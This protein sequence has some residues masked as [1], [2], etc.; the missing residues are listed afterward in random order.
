MSENKLSIPIAKTLRV[1]HRTLV[2]R[3][4]TS[5]R[6]GCIKSPDGEAFAPSPEGNIKGRI[7]GSPFRVSHRNYALEGLI[8][9]LKS[10]GAHTCSAFA[11]PFHTFMISPWLRHEKTPADRDFRSKQESLVAMKADSQGELHRAGCYCLTGCGP[12]VF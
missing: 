8:E 5:S 3:A 1:S 10:P 6:A 11:T 4:T 12:G 9:A 7:H 2:F